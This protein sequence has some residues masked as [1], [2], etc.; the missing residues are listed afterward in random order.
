MLACVSRR[1]EAEVS[2]MSGETSSMLSLHSDSL[3]LHVL[4]ACVSFDNNVNTAI[5]NVFMTQQQF[6]QK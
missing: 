1:L 4:N 2:P 6:G 5:I 3:R